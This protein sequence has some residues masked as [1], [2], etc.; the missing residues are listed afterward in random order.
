MKDPTTAALSEFLAGARV[1]VLPAGAVHDAKRAIYNWFGLTL[2]AR[3]HPAV[4]I[5]REWVVSLGGSGATAVGGVGTNLLSAALVNG[6]ASHVEDFDDTH[7]ATI[8]HPTGP[9]WSAVL[10]LAEQAG[11]SGEDALTA[12]V[13]GVDVACRVGEAVYPS[14]YDRGHHITATVGCL[15]AAAGAATLLRL[16][17]EQVGEALGIASTYA[18]GLRGTFGSMAKPLHPGKAA[19]EGITAAQLAQRG[20]T[21]GDMGLES[22]LGFC[23][24]LSDEHDLTCVTDGLGERW[25]IQDNS[26]KPF[27]AGVVAHAAIDGILRHRQAGLQAADVR[28]IELRVHRR[29]KELTGNPTPRLGLEGKFSVQHSVAVA[30]LDGRAGPAQYSDQRVN[31]RDSMELAERVT[32]VVDG[33]LRT[34]EAHVAVTRKDGSGESLHVRHALGSLENPMTDEHLQDKVNDLLADLPPRRRASLRRRV[35]ELDQLADVRPL[36]GELAVR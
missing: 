24:V 19:M 25:L 21:S 6:L 17:P 2:Q 29:V 28:A 3:D 16:S 27:A 9:V 4:S 11:A 30:L 22:P 8:I 36:A 18:S 31:A 20:F 14:H 26:I 32:L 7:Y 35:L 1:D 34:D 13:L 5:A 23:N 12:F 10:A 15:G 33:D